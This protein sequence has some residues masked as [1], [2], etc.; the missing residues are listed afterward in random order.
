MTCVH[1]RL[2]YDDCNTAFCTREQAHQGRAGEKQALAATSLRAAEPVL[3][4]R[5]QST[6]ES[7]SAH[8]HT[9]SPEQET[10]RS[11]NTCVCGSASCIFIDAWQSRPCMVIGPERLCWCAAAGK[12][13][14]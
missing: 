1:L 11:P 3:A 14:H 6:K 7:S 12:R 5:E 10:V 8:Q 13:L 2:A 4:T 9:A